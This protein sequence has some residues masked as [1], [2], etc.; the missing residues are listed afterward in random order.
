MEIDPEKMR[1][2][3]SMGQP[4]EVFEKGLRERFKEFNLRVCKKRSIDPEE[5]EVAKLLE[6]PPKRFE[7][8]LEN[9][10]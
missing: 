10:S 7:R 4:K 9:N 2:V 5:K 1:L 6:L 8:E 3:G